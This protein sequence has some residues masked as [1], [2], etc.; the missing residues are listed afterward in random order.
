MAEL[1]IAGDGSI[2]YETIGTKINGMTL[3]GWRESS[4]PCEVEG[5]I[6]CIKQRFNLN[7]VEAP[8]SRPRSDD[9]LEVDGRV[10]NRVI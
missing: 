10:F 5:H 6:L 7:L 3:R 4:E 2:Q 8:R 1:A 9:V